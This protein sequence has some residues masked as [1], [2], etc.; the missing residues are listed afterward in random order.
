MAGQLAKE[1][2]WISGAPVP[3]LQRQP[4]R[5]LDRRGRQQREIK[6]R[7]TIGII[8]C[9]PPGV[10][11]YVRQ[12]TNGLSSHAFSERARQ[13]QP[14][15]PTATPPTTQQST[16][17]SI[18]TSSAEQ[19][20]VDDSFMNSPSRGWDHTQAS[21]SYSLRE[22]NSVQSSAGAGIDGH[23]LPPRPPSF[24]TPR[25]GRTRTLTAEPMRC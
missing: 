9:A 10:T 20:R 22:Q 12:Y 15:Y 14:R 21:P 18:A 5:N 8:R 6:G 17:T 16:P 3:Q 19:H 24:A 2:T 11:G 13:P 1:H 7:D 4:S 25:T 23:G